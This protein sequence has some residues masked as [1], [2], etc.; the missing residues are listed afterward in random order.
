MR[1]PVRNRGGNDAKAG[2]NVHRVSAWWTSGPAGLAKCETALS[3][4]HFSGERESGSTVG[5]WSPE[6]L[7]LCSLATCFIT[8]FE[9]E[10]RNSRFVYA[11]LSVEVEG[12]GRDEDERSCDLA[13]IVLRPTLTVQ[14]E[15]TLTQGMNLIWRAQSRCMVAHVLSIP[16]NIE[17]KIE[18]SKW[19]LAKR[20]AKAALN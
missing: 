19:P 18:T 3:A 5:R 16:V 17:P 8:T 15:E 6:Q 2:E 7:L 14:S 12:K 13:E 4:I 9:A 11:D 20:I 1:N 10:A